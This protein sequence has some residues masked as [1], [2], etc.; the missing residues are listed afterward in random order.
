[1]DL[2]RDREFVC[3]VI[4]IIHSQTCA[5]RSCSEQEMG[6]CIWAQCNCHLITNTAEVSERIRNSCH[7]YNIVCIMPTVFQI[8]GE[9]IQLVIPSLLPLQNPFPIDSLVFPSL[10][11]IAHT[12]TFASI[13][14]KINCVQFNSFN[15]SFLWPSHANFAFFWISNFPKTIDVGWCG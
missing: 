13:S 7:T 9:C 12:R 1:M 3:Y 5:F 2:A 10:L 8:I 11:Q 15:S 14:P 6:L 4:H